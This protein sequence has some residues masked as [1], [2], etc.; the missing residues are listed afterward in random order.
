MFIAHKQENGQEETIV[1]H[2]SLTAE[3]ATLFG[4]KIGL[5][6]YAQVCSW[7]HDI[8]KY[9]EEFQK[10]IRGSNV[11]VDHSTAGAQK[12]IEIY[13]DLFGKMCA[14]CIA[15]H[16]T[17]LPN[18]G[19][20]GDNEEMP[21]LSGRMKKPIKDYFAYENE[22]SKAYKS[23]KDLPSPKIKPCDN[24]GFSY[25]FLI[26]MLYSCLVDADFLAT[27]KFM[28]DIS[29]R[30]GNLS[31]NDLNSLLDIKLK[32]F[33]EPQPNKSKL[34]VLRT[35]ILKQ[36]IEKATK[37]KGIFTLTVPTGGGK[38][39]SS[40][41]FAIKH[42]IEHKMDRIIYVIPFT[43]I[44]EQN[45]GEFK[46]VF[47]ND[48]V[49]EHHSNFD[50]NVISDEEISRKLKLASENWDVPIVVTTNVQFFES[51][52][53]NRSSKCRKLHNI[54]NSV[55]IFD[56]AQSIP[57]SYLKA[58][59]Y[60]IWELANNY[61][62]T[63]ILCTATQPPF[64]EIFPKNTAIT[65]IIENQ[66]ELYTAFKKVEIINKGILTD[67][68]LI[69]NINEN[70]TALCIVNTKKHALDIYESLSNKD[71]YHLSAGM[72]PKHRS[73]VIKKIKSCLKNNIPCK[74]I[75]TQI[76]EAGVDIDFPVVY[77]EIAGID[78]IIQSAG[79]CNREGNLADLGKVYIFTP[80]NDAYI[81]SIFKT[82]IA[83]TKDIISKYDDILLPEAVE[84][85]FKEL[86][87]FKGKTSNDE[88]EIMEMFNFYKTLNFSFE[89]IA[90]EFNLI[91]DNTHSIVIAY[92]DVAIKNIE[93]IKN[94]NDCKNSMRALQQ[95]TVNV[96]HY[97]FE[98]LLSSGNIECLIGNTFVLKD[99]SL[100]SEEF[101]LNVDMKNG[102]AIFM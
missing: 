63:A 14:Y 12:T 49:L 79:R 47:G 68:D 74:V 53:A 102:Q 28:N 58:C 59:T 39:F 94:E 2:L 19:G 83:I 81:P 21:T 8:G 100:Y 95:Y 7:Y 10:R 4:D 24:A 5:K 85:Y 11:K 84:Y 91:D 89:D 92:D 75:S 25:A 45:A 55:V 69:K 48:N 13:G 93:S 96:Y 15:G 70:E 9:S 61:N 72:C 80:E 38:T 32:T 30:G 37:P 35:K 22:L 65:E 6:E 40:L 20:K 60:S 34:N 50:F 64:K 82:Q 29:L 88:N 71:K 33:L 31:I 23:P 26:R 57:L 101:G 77:R 76:L 99:N 62:S 46:K 18:F 27:E 17:G 41:S 1:E 3:F 54:A 43:S 73:E 42:A 51:L 78:S 90:K 36:C 66:E 97:Q 52:F 16:H 98:Q 56:E 86:Y 67:D 44:I 87:F